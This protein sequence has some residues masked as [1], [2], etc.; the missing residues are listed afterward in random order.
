M[1]F[2]GL[3]K[4]WSTPKRRALVLGTVTEGPAVRSFSFAGG[5]CE[6]KKKAMVSLQFAEYWKT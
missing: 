6:F 1:M 5:G 4:R 3:K 2:R